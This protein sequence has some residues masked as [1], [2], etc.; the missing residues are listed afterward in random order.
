[1]AHPLVVATYV[2][3]SHGGKLL[4]IEVSTAIPPEQ[5]PFEYGG[6][7]VGAVDLSLIG[8]REILT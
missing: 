2:P 7:F 8:G 4:A 5:I 6:Y 3:C 1:M